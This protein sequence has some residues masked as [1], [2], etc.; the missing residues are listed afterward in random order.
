MKDGK[1]LTL[2]PNKH[3]GG[4]KAFPLLTIKNVTR[5]DM[6]EYTCVCMN[7]VGASVSENSAFLNVYCKSYCK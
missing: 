5:D 7:E 3:E 6:G 1:N 2:I 4:T